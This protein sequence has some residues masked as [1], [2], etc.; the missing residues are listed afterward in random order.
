[1]SNI[2][3]WRWVLYLSPIFLGIGVVVASIILGVAEF[4]LAN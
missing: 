3:F 4:G 1:M 2:S